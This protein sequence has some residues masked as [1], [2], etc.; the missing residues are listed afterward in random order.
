MRL[1]IL[2]AVLLLAGVRYGQAAEVQVLSAAA[3]KSPLR[4]SMR[5]IADASLDRMMV[6]TNVV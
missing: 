4:I 1:T 2:S 6:M 3:V 5:P